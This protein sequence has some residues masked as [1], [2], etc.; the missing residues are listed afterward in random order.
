MTN[1]HL[2]RRN[3]GETSRLAAESI[4]TALGPKHRMILAALGSICPATDLEMAIALSQLGYGREESCRRYVRTL[5]E[6]HGRLVPALDSNGEQVRHL[7]PTGRWAE[8]WIPG[9]APPPERAKTDTIE[10]RIAR[11]RPI[12]IDEVEHVRFD[13]HDYYLAHDL[14]EAL[15]MNADDEQDVDV[16]WPDSLFD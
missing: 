14:L 9:Y 1:L 6:E 4:D 8:C 2:A 10:A 12:R 11:C 7:N 15:V 3:D 13:G 5:R 16:D